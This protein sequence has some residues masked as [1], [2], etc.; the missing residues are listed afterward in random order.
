MS[1]K[2]SICMLMLSAISMQA[3]DRSSRHVFSAK[4]VLA[5]QKEKDE[6]RAQLWQGWVR[7]APRSFK[8]Q[9]E[10]TLTFLEKIT[11]D[12]ISNVGCIDDY[13]AQRL[14]KL[15]LFCQTDNTLVESSRR[16]VTLWQV[17]AEMKKNVD[18]LQ[19]SSITSQ[20]IEHVY[21]LSK[22]L[23][24]GATHQGQQCLIASGICRSCKRLIEIRVTNGILERCCKDT[25]FCAT[26]EHVGHACDCCTT[27]L[28]DHLYVQ[29]KQIAIGLGE[30]AIT[31]QTQ[32]EKALLK[33][34]IFYG[35]N[36]SNNK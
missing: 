16:S 22:D 12:V 35:N 7:E 29:L 14:F 36:K 3:M 10:E 15:A 2:K 27:K 13:R 23:A 26:P 24:V 21:A 8:G 20:N 4:K 19:G 25:V 6:A 28:R 30:N 34:A 31:P 11:V 17:L 5:S 33:W 18:T 1:F 32:E 9:P